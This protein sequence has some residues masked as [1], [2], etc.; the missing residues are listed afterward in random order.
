MIVVGHVQMKCIHAA[1]LPKDGVNLPGS[2][3]VHDMGDQNLRAIEQDV[4][5]FQV[6][7]ASFLDLR[8]LT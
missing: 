8:D 1:W 5:F 4:I 2:Y 3:F 7:C 6:K